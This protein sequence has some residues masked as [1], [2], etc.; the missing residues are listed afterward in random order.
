MK[1]V[2]LIILLN[3]VCL[4]EKMERMESAEEMTDVVKAIDKLGN[5]E[6]IVTSREAE[7]STGQISPK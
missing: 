1:P 6:E 2:Q 5:T 3:L 7:T 4:M